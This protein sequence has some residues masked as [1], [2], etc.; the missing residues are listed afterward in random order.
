MRGHPEEWQQRQTG[1]EINS[2]NTQW[3]C[4]ADRQV[5]KSH[6]GKNTI[7]ANVH[8]STN[9]CKCQYEA[10][11]DTKPHHQGHI[12]LD[13]D[14]KFMDLTSPDI[15]PRLSFNDPFKDNKKADGMVQRKGFTAYWWILM[16][17]VHTCATVFPGWTSWISLPLQHSCLLS[18][19]QMPDISSA[20]LLLCILMRGSEFQLWTSWKIQKQD[21]HTHTPQ[22]NI[23]AFSLSL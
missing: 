16:K 5:K 20:D 11:I 18:E 15:A 1:T 14:D 3:G 21:T 4:H 8:I 12:C 17:T 7:T 13:G 10:T 2:I 19:M 23:H 9:D 22:K 6:L